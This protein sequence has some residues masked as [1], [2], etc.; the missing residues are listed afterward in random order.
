[1][2]LITFRLSGCGSTGYYVPESERQAE[3][4]SRV[5]GRTAS[6]ELK[7]SNSAAPRAIE[8]GFRKPFEQHIAGKHSQRQNQRPEHHLSATQ[9]MGRRW[10]S[11]T[12]GQS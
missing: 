4:H 6:T 8:R 1:M 9:L 12:S 10:C 11:L 7:S 2:M 3:S 5:I